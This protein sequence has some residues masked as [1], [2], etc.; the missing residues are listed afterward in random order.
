VESPYQDTTRGFSFRPVLARGEP[1]GPLANLRRVAADL[2]RTQTEGTV[3]Q[4]LGSHW[5]LL[6]SDGLE[7]KYRIYDLAMRLVGFLDAPYRSNIPHPQ[8]VPVPSGADTEYLM[9]TFDGTPLYADLLGYGTH[10][11]FILMRAS[12]KAA[13]HPFR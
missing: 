12:A 5:F 8:I 6:A 9:L 11:D 1:G 10:G 7:R 2:T 13:G 3:L 4:K